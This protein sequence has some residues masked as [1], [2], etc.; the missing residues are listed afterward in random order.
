MGVKEEELVVTGLGWITS[1]LVTEHG[2][3]SHPVVK[4]TGYSS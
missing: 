1:P 3:D 2:S 4:V